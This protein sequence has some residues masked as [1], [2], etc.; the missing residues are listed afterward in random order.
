MDGRSWGESI[1]QSAINAPFV[2]E[3]A[4]LRPMAN[5]SLSIVTEKMELDDLHSRNSGRNINRAAAMETS[6][7]PPP[8]R[9]LETSITADASF[10]APKS[11]ILKIRKERG[12]K[13]L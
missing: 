6:S 5:A 10:L 1:K 11:G 7:F 13:R 9:I 3:N 8:F 4:I 12:S 2:N